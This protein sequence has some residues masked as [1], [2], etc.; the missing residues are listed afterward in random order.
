MDELKPVPL[1]WAQEV[2]RVVLFNRMR[3]IH[4][5][6]RGLRRLITTRYW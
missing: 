5:R 2:E 1:T 3:R 4:L 6:K